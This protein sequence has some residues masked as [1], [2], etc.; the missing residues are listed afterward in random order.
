MFWWGK[1][2]SKDFV[3]YKQITPYAMTGPD[4]II[5]YFTG[6]VV[7]DKNNTA[8]FGKEAYVAAYTIF[9]KDSK[10][11]HRAY[12]LAM[13]GKYSLYEG[14]R[15]WIYGVQSSENPRYFGTSLL[16]DG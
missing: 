7:I 11:R 10:N 13:M 3:H 15:F 1:V 6:S 2:E 5:S 9:E 16:R 8:G 12:L 14:N 4:H